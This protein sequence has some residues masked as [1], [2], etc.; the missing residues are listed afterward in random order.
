M[1]RRAHARGIVLIGSYLFLSGVLTY[2]ATLSTRLAVAQHAADSLIQRAQALDLARAGVA[3]L[4]EELYQALVTQIYPVAF[5]GDAAQTFA[6]LDKLGAGTLSGLDPQ[7]APPQNAAHKLSGGGIT[8]DPR[9]IR[10]PS[11]PIGL[12]LVQVWVSAVSPPPGLSTSAFTRHV[13]LTA[14]AQVGGSRR[15]IEVIEEFG[16]GASPVFRYAYFINNYGWF[17]SPDDFHLM[18]FGDVRSNGNL[19][20]DT[21]G[22]GGNEVNGDLYASDNPAIKDPLTKAPADGSILPDPPQPNN[23]QARTQEEYWELKRE[24]SEEDT[25]VGWG[26]MA[27][28]TRRL[29]LPS[30]PTLNGDEALLPA[31]FGYDGE[32]PSPTKPKQAR[33]EKQPIQPMPYLGDLSLYKKFATNHQRTPLS[34]FGGGQGS[35]LRYRIDTDGDGDYFDGGSAQR[36]L[37]EVYDLA[38]G[39]D[40]EANTSDDGW[41][42][43][44]LGQSTQPIVIDGPV[45]IPGDVIMKGEVRGR[46]TLYAGRNIHIVG[47]LEYLDPPIWPALGRE[48][49]N[50]KLTAFLGKDNRPTLGY[51][52]DDG[53]GHGHLQPDPC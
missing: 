34:P 53:G 24:E 3:Q 52:C 11:Q 45:V 19:R 27:R 41:P 6:W 37:A 31:G 51:L 33:Y 16:L 26:T 21:T 50:G 48:P 36:E 49:G 2:T 14:E 44:L 8:G 40:Q 5:Q 29:V 30:Q 20:F 32:F 28:P 4:R 17:E 15:R 12:G 42:L 39:P 1:R 10:L 38:K 25:N 7:F 18:V 9:V 46:G 22:S 43:V 47:D 35:R 13:T 23:P